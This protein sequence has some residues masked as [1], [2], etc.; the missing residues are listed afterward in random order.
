M[1]YAAQ[2]T[3]TLTTSDSYQTV[4]VIDCKED[5]PNRL[6]EACCFSIVEGS[7]S[8]DGASLV[9]FADAKFKV[10]SAPLNV[11]AYYTDLDVEASL[12]AGH[13]TFV[14]VYGAERYLRV[15]AKSA[16]TTTPASITVYAYRRATTL[17]VNTPKWYAAIEV[18]DNSG[19]KHRLSCSQIQ[20]RLSGNAASDIQFTVPDPSG[21]I[22]SWLKKGCIGYAYVDYAPV[23]FLPAPATLK[24]K[25]SVEDIERR[26][27]NNSY[28]QVSV[29]GQ[30][31]FYRVILERIVIE[32]YQD[33]TVE[34]ILTS[35]LTAYVP[36][37]SLDIA[38]AAVNV[39]DIRFNYRPLKDVLDVLAELCA[40]NYYFTANGA[41][42][43]AAK[44]AVNSNITYS[45]KD[46]YT[47]ASVLDT[48]RGVRNTV[49][50][51]GG[52]YKQVDQEQ[53]AH[54]GAAALHTYSYAQSFTPT[55]AQLTQISLHLNQ[56]GAPAESLQ[57]SIC[58]DNNGVPGEKV[59]S[60]TYDPEYADSRGWWPL[61]VEANLVPNGKYWLVL[62]VVGDAVDTWL[63]SHDNLSSGTHLYSDDA[64]ASWTAVM[65]SFRFAFRT[66]YNVPIV[67]RVA[68]YS[69]RGKYRQRDTLIQ[70]SA[71]LSRET[72][73]AVAKAKLAELQEKQEQLPA[74]AVKNF[75]VP[76][77]N[78][79]VTFD[80]D[81]I[82]LADSFTVAEISWRW[83]GGNPCIIY[84]L[85]LGESV[86]SLWRNLAALKSDVRKL[87]VG[88]LGA[89]YG[90]VDMFRDFNE[91]PLVDSSVDF[92]VQASGTFKVGHCKVGFCNCA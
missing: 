65:D 55:R 13:K 57:G 44:K 76:T 54:A 64:G 30:D 14:D 31:Y 50:V 32:T 45:E 78:S 22:R 3:H 84:T 89:E 79:Y 4:C 25:F 69:S 9:G 15:Q 40:A 47:P 91:S 51:L 23:T 11:E 75:N 61:S 70:D 87:Q 29:K 6:I 12:L 67:T 71:I 68:D 26:Y 38:D 35:I 53:T 62:D 63:W 39:E 46:V 7:L 59:A 48:L 49:Y 27:P 41:F 85:Q 83:S 43:F 21:T 86:E 1:T 20:L 42:K 19:V 52:Q 56:Q 34:A 92:S 36:D 90:T 72:A 10:Q 82:D 8:A 17:T 73:R 24:L 2:S 60:F 16:Y 88:S 66:Y 33:T 58:R 18:A 5:Y 77:V 81:S 80:L 74:V 28:C 37:V